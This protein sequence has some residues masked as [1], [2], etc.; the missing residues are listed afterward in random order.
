MICRQGDGGTQAS[1]RIGAGDREIAAEF[2]H[3]FANTAEPY[4]GSSPGPLKA[5][6]DRLRKSPAKILNFK[7]SAIGRAL[8]LHVYAGAGG[9]PMR[10]GQTFL[11]RAEQ[12]QFDGFGHAI[13]FRSSRRTLVE[14]RKVRLNLH[15]GTL[16]EAFDE[17]VGRRLKAGF[18]E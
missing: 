18:I 1:S 3:A 4:P 8:K 16:G 7:N 5:F 6:Y 15:V 10:I 12:R 9:V 13:D 14:S 2:L 11:E 17:P